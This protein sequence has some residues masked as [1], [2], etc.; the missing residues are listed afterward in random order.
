MNIPA[1]EDVVRLA[2]SEHQKLIEEL[3]DAQCMMQRG[4]VDGTI[5]PDPVLSTLYGRA[6]GAISDLSRRVFGLDDGRGA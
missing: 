5:K 4:E 1:N 6:A 3:V 2:N